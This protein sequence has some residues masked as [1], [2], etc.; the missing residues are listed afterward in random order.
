MDGFERRTE[1]KKEQI[2]RAALDLFKRY[3]FEKVSIADIAREARVSHVTIYT[4]FGNKDALVRDIIQKEIND[5][6]TRLDEMISADTPFP[7]KMDD[8]LVNKVELAAQYQGQLMR[9]FLGNAELHE[10]FDSVWKDKISGMIKKIFAEGQAGGY[11]SRDVSFETVMMFYDILLAGW[12]A[13]DNKLRNLDSR[14]VRELNHLF[15]YGLVD[16]I[17]PPD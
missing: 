8:L 6:V 16:K 14:T 5:F 17:P 11:I 4:H 12:Y 1:Q 9:I 2:R 13:C 3:G 7:R 15:L 10:F